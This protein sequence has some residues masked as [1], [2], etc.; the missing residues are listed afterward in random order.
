MV[1][2]HLLVTTDRN[3][4]ATLLIVEPN[5][6]AE[7][8]QLAAEVFRVLRNRAVLEGEDVRAGLADLR[9]GRVSKL[10]SKK[11]DEQLPMTDT[12]EPTRSRFSTPTAR[13]SSGC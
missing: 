10:T 1:G 8:R 5:T 11:L 9:E 13:G 2:G 7:F 12:E 4:C 6:D 3:R